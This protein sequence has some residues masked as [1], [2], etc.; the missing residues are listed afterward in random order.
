MDPVLLM[1][2]VDS[3]CLLRDP[4]SA[5]GQKSSSLLRAATRCESRPRTRLS[6]SFMLISPNPW[7]PLTRDGIKPDPAVDH[8]HLK[9]GR[10]PW[11]ATVTCGAPACLTALVRASCNTR[12]RQSASVPWQI[13]RKPIVTEV[14]GHTVLF[15]ERAR[16]RGQRPPFPRP[17]NSSLAECRRC[18][19]AWMSRARSAACV[20]V[21]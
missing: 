4:R 3:T 14:D 1:L 7:L 5:R 16:G 9:L 10:P 13:L 11:S 17:S 18:T 21:S 6:R 20:E 15:E 19:R 12:N 8:V 2:P